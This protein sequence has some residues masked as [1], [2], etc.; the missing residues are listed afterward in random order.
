M[1]FK[2]ERLYKIAIAILLSIV[3]ALTSILT[4]LLGGWMYWVSEVALEAGDKKEWM[5]KQ[6]KQINENKEDLIRLKEK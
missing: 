6:Q 5:L 4:F 1:A 3:G 2:S